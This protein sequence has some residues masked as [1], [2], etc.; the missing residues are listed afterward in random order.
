M[1]AGL[2]TSGDAR[3]SSDSSGALP[4]QTHRPPAWSGLPHV[5]ATVGHVVAS[6]PDGKLSV[7][8]RSVCRLLLLVVV[9]VTGGVA[10]A[11]AVNFS[12][13]CTRLGP[14]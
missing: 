8:G 6:K 2:V 1:I 13:E 4:H 12:M 11:A 7:L 10:A 5:S 14:I 3:G 9:V